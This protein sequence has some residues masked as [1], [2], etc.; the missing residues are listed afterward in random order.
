LKL[1]F[2]SNT[3]EDVGGGERTSFLAQSE[4]N[5]SKLLTHSA[6]VEIVADSNISASTAQ[7]LLAVVARRKRHGYESQPAAELPSRIS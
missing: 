4:R 7:R 6:R 5:K 2:L 3:A 1:S